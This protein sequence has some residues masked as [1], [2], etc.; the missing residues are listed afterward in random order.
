MGTVLVHHKQYKKG[1]GSSAFEAE[2]T[3][4]CII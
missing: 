4:P 1:D 3:S 2:E